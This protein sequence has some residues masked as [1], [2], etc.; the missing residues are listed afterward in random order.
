MV[1]LPLLFGRLTAADYE[2]QVAS[3]LRIDALRAKMHCIEDPAFT[4]DYHDPEKRSIPNALLIELNDGN[5]LEETVEYPIG[6]MRRRSDGIP[7]LEAKF[8]TNLARR[9]PEDAQRRI[10]DACADQA[11]LE[12][13]PVDEF[14]DLF[15]AGNTPAALQAHAPHHSSNPLEEVATR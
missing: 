15:V 4:A 6:H 10:L 5:T 11:G 2:D 1:A 9:F 13:I 14:V 8:R 3:D 12:S 7:L